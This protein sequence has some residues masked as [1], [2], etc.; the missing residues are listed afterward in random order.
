MG[1]GEHPDAQCWCAVL[2]RVLSR[3]RGGG[4][5]VVSK[6]DDAGDC[7]AGQRGRYGGGNRTEEACFSL[8][9]VAK[10]GSGMH[11]DGLP[12]GVLK[13]TSPETRT[14]LF[15]GAVGILG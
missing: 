7:M 10:K 5:V 12:M 8:K 2:G 11:G 9:S 14:Q 6:R 4:A 1:G 3:R 13:I 15:G